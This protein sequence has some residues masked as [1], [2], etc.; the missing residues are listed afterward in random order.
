VV[1][2]Q[3]WFISMLFFKQLNWMPLNL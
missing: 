2:L 3:F 1:Q